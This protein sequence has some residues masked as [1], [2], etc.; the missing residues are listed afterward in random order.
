MPNR[1]PPYNASPDLPHPPRQG[2]SEAGRRLRHER[3]VEGVRLGMHRQRETP[4]RTGTNVLERPEHW[5]SRAVGLH[6]HL[7]VPLAGRRIREGI[8]DALE[9]HGLARLDGVRA[10]E[11][12]ERPS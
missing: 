4:A 9:R 6:A 3:S 2:P 8:D 5:T 11:E 1:A 7:D 12:L 10:C